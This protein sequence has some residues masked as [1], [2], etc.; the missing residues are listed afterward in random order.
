MLAHE[1]AGRGADVT[2]LHGFLQTGGSWAEQVKLLGSGHR[3]ILPDLPGHGGSR[4]A[5][6]TLPA[7][8][9]AL[10]ELW[11]HL[12]VERTHLVGYSMGGRLALHAAAGHPERIA[13]LLTLG[14]H[15]G[16]EG[17]LAE[18]RRSEDEALAAR[19]EAR[20]IDWLA[21]HWA[22]LPLFA[23]LGRRDPETLARL[24]AMR[25]AQDPHAIARALRGMGAAATPAF[26]DRLGVIAAP[27]LFVSG[28]LD[29]AYGEAA[30]RLAGCVPGGRRAEVPGAGHSAHLEAPEAFSAVLAAHLSTR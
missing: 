25:R 5:E 2:F 13:S 27:S 30:R 24:D 29:P 8:T 15:A 23:G 1:V 11:D 16:L 9:A 3:A 20:G 6:A 10:V 12:G 26:W 22:A 4:D 17:A 19:I 18:R 7:A 14:A 28:A 21:D